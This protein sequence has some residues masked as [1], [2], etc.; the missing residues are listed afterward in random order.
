MEDRGLSFYYLFL[1][2]LI[3]REVSFARTCSVAKLVGLNNNAIY[4]FKPLTIL[5]Q[6]AANELLLPL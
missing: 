2:P 5:K 4:L 1:P 6:Q 3:T